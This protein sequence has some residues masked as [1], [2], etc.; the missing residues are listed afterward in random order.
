MIY[1]AEE[2]ATRTALRIAH[3][4]HLAEIAA[5]T[6]V[7]LLSYE[8]TSEGDKCDLVAEIARRPGIAARMTSYG[9]DYILAE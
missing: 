3:L 2:R 6:D 1:T 5:M 8:P 7:E 9:W 4:A